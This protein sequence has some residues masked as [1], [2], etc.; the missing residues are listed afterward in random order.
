MTWYYALD[1]DHIVGASN[2]GSDSRIRG[3]AG[4]IP[5]HDSGQV[6]GAVA[7]QGCPLLF[8][9]GDDDFPHLPVRQHLACL[10]VHYL[11]VNIIIPVVHGSLLLAVNGNSRPV[12]FR[13]AIDVK[14]VHS[15]L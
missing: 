4:T 6:M 5:R 7:N 15:Q 1:L 14:Q 8:Q 11:D 2:Q 12:Y 10:W 13:K 9:G 3:T